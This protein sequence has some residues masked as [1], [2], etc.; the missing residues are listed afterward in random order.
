MRFPYI[1][2]HVNAS[3]YLFSLAAIGDYWGLFAPLLDDSNEFAYYVYGLKGELLCNQIFGW[4]VV[5]MINCYAD[6]G[7]DTGLIQLCN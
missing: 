5:P 2:Q 7:K 4:R 3:V 1:V 6:R